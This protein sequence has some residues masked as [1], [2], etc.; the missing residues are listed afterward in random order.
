M[1][2]FTALFFVIA[3]AFISCKKEEIRHEVKIQYEL[4]DDVS[5]VKVKLKVDGNFQWAEWKYDGGDNYY[6]NGNNNGMSE[7]VFQLQ[8]VAIVDFLGS[9]TQNARY[10]GRLAIQLPPIAS[11]V[12]FTGLSAASLAN[13]FPAMTGEYKVEFSL[14]DP[15]P[16]IIKSTIIELKDAQADRLNF[17]ESVQFDIPRFY[18]N[19]EHTVYLTISKNDELHYV[20]KSS[21]HLKEKYLRDRILFGKLQIGSTPALFLEANW[22]P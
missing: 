22:K 9:D 8:E 4:T 10:N 7:Y 15:I 12:E 14:C 2:S 16:S 13:Y 11:K 19:A 18:E 1:K 20:I 6:P 21:I 5:P 3:I 17:K